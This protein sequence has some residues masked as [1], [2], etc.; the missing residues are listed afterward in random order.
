VHSGSH[1][2]SLA[3]E[4]DAHRTTVRVETPEPHLRL[5]HMLDDPQASGCRRT[6][7]SAT[8]FPLSLDRGLR[9]RHSPGEPC[10]RGARRTVHECSSDSRTYPKQ[11]HLDV[12]RIQHQMPACSGASIPVRRT[13]C[14]VLE[15]SAI[16]RCRHQRYRRPYQP[17]RMPLQSEREQAERTDTESKTI[18]CLTSWEWSLTVEGRLMTLQYDF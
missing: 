12:S 13:A 3:V 4:P 1:T 10:K 14:C 9:P 6:A 2:G 8:P 11:G 16:A 7:C 17:V 5:R 15:L 18:E